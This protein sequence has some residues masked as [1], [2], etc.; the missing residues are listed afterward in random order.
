MRL[1]AK[2]GNLKLDLYEYRWPIAQRSDMPLVK[3]IHSQADGHFD[4]GSIPEG[5]Y[6]L[7]IDDSWGGASWFDVEITQGVKATHSVMIDV[8]PV[9]PDCTGG[10][11]FLVQN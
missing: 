10:H 9:Y 5:H 7:V 8:S 6:A 11:E 4:F 1:R 3:S 2:L